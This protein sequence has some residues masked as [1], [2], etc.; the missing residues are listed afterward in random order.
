MS[1]GTST[2]EEEKTEAISKSDISV[3]PLVTPLIAGPGAMGAAILLMADQEG[4]VAGQAI[5]VA[6]ILLILLLTFVSM[7]LAGKTLFAAGPPLEQGA[8][9][10]EPELD[11]DS[12]ALLIA[13]ATEDGRELARLPL[14]SQPVFDGMIAARGKLYITLRNGTVRCL[15]GK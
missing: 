11:R 1:G 14:D 15:A 7:L 10:K 8:G 12:P 2:T 5:I 6:S 4:N 9:A 3:F 13:F